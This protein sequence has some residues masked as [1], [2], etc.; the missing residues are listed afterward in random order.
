[1]RIC[2]ISREYPPETGFGGIATFAR[3]LAHGLKQLGHEVEVVSLAKETEKQVDD[4]G[5]MV[6]RVLPFK[7]PGDLGAVAKCM[8]YSRYVFQTTLALWRKFQE[9]HEKK[10][11]DVIDSPEL[12][13]EGIYPALTRAVPLVIRLYTPHSKFIAEQLHSVAASFDHMFVAM[14]ERVAMLSADVLTSPSEDLADFVACDLGYE[15]NKIALVHNPIDPE[16]FSPDGERLPALPGKKRVLFV[17]RLEER[18]GIAYLIDAVPKILAEC[19]DTHFIIIG[20]DTLNA[21]GGQ[22][23]VLADL[24]ESLSRSNAMEAVT[25]VPRIPLVELPKYYRSADVCVVP[26]LYDN[27]PY[28]CL[29]AMACGRAVVGTSAGGTREYIVDGESGLIVPAKDSD[30]LAEAICELLQDDDLRLRLQINARQRVL[31]CFQ[32]EKIAAKTVSLYELA[33]KKH[34]ELSSNKLYLKD[35]QQMTVDAAVMLYA[36]DRMIYNLLYQESWR[37][38]FS[39]WWHYFIHRPRLFLAKLVLRL[40]RSSGFTGGDKAGAAGQSSF[41]TWLESQVQQKHEDPLAQLLADMRAANIASSS[42]SLSSSSK[43]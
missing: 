7:V 14:V 13:A 20:D 2:L 41:V 15:R 26:S 35:T 8:P 30:K 38:R 12:L 25:F 1:M 37:F 29:E 10:P 42:S 3:H 16:E 24:K 43:T 34:R 36:Y 32:R 11:F 27:S 17:G 18:K 5:V 39:Y 23:S 31:D 33:I 4:D 40:A 21:S 6:H 28:T 9:L 19:P 22:R